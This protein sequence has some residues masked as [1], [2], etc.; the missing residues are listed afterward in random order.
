MKVTDEIVQA[1]CNAYDDY[2][3]GHDNVLLR[4][5]A[6]GHGMRAALEAVMKTAWVSISDKLPPSFV[7]VLVLDSL[8]GRHIAI[9]VAEYDQWFSADNNHLYNVIRWMLIPEYKET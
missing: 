2:N 8:E 1:A 5:V 6:T 9:Y 7:Q 3:K 4:G